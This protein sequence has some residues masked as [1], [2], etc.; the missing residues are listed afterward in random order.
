M[1]TVAV[2]LP[3]GREFDQFGI[4]VCRSIFNIETD[5][6]I[7]L[8]LGI[9]KSNYD[10]SLLKD[11]LPKNVKWIFESEHVRSCAQFFN[12]AYKALKEDYFMILVDDYLI[13]GNIFG[14]IDF[15]K[16]RSFPVATFGVVSD[17]PEHDNKPN[18]IAYHPEAIGHGGSKGAHPTFVATNIYAMKTSLAKKLFPNNLY[19]LERYY[20]DDLL[21]FK[22]QA[23]CKEIIPVW[24]GGAMRS[25]TEPATDFS[26]GY[27]AREE[28]KKYVNIVKSI[29]KQ[30][31]GPLLL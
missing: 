23:K 27:D 21:A 10:R 5:Y 20:S 16:D 4:D 3:C 7:T 30:L 6:E 18:E 15:I 14:I 13:T 28:Y 29:E 1:T 26:P 12:A 31:E 8:Y 17:F 2:L 9:K 19:E 22:L 24:V 25:T 11:Q